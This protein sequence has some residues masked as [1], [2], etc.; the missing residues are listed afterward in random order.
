MK[1]ELHLNG[2]HEIILKPETE[3][4]RLIL[5][6]MAES[7]EKG[8]AVTMQATRTTTPGVEECPPGTL[9]RA[10]IGVPA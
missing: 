8:R 2:I 10:V 9:I 7:A 5:S 1:V 4:E 6:T 3:I